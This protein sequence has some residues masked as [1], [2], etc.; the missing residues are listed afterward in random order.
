MNFF[1]KRHCDRLSGC[2]AAPAEA[3]GEQKQREERAR[4]HRRRRHPRGPPHPPQFEPGTAGPRLSRRHFID[5]LMEKFSS[6]YF[7]T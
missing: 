7:D 2:D 3:A 4:A 1:V 5:L 6:A